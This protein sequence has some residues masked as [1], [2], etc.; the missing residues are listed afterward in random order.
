MVYV[1]FV[2]TPAMLVL[3]CAYV[4]FTPVHFNA[5]VFACVGLA[6]GIVEIANGV[7]VNYLKPREPAGPMPVQAT[8]QEDNPWEDDNA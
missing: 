8:S 7:Y 4:A 3:Y 5:E 1:P 2:L 6:F